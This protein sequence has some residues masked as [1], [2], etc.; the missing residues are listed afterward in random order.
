MYIEVHR[1]QAAC[2]RPLAKLSSKEKVQIGYTLL[3]R[4]DRDG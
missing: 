3:S 4:N 1:R 2:S